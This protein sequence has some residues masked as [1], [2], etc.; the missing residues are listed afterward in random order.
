MPRDRWV[1][2]A[3][4]LAAHLWLWTVLTAQAAAVAPPRPAAMTLVAV[5]APAAAPVPL[6]PPVAVPVDIRAEVGLPSLAVAADEGAPT[7]ADCGLTAAIE[8][9]LQA[10]PPV[11]AALDRMPPGSRSPSDAV[12]LW[13]GTWADPAG[14][15]GSA[16]LQP[17]RDAVAQRIAAAPAECRDAVLG[18]PRLLYVGDGGRFVVL[19]FGS[20]SWSWSQLA[21]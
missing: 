11:R 1:V 3:L 9:A 6:P 14:V 20:G 8:A 10:S 15:G 13:D 17:I 19:A 5:R 7:A 4:L 16:T 2:L 12:M 21:G 18:G